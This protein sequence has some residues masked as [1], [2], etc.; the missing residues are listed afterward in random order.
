MAIELIF[1]PAEWSP[2]NKKRMA[3]DRERSCITLFLRW[4]LWQ[5]Y[6]CEGDERPWS[7]GGVI[8]EQQFL[9]C[10]SLLKNAFGKTE[11]CHGHCE[12]WYRAYTISIVTTCIQ[13]N[14][15][16][17]LK[18]KPNFSILLCINKVSPSLSH[19]YTFIKHH[20]NEPLF[21]SKYP[22]I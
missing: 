20:H 6:A 22:E 4:S 16:T 11:Q 3:A 14:W 8:E 19:E 7:G 18:T 10:V 1:S 9:G 15:S 13:T 12:A 21:I 17:R 5:F 2:L